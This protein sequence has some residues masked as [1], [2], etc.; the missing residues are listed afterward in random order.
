MLLLSTSLAIGQAATGEVNGTVT[1][2]SGAFVPDATVT[3]TNQGTNISDKASTNAS[4]HFLF[5]N[6][7]PGKYALAV[8]KQGFKKVEVPAFELGVNQAITQP[9]SLGVGSASETVEV[10]AQSPLLQASSSELGTVIPEKA[11]NDLPL[12]GRNFTQLLTLTPGATPVSTAQ[13]S[14]VGVLDAGI[15]GIPGSDFSKPSLHGQQN[16]STLYFLDGIINTDLRGPVYGVLPII[17]AMQEFKVQSHNDKAEYGGVTGGIV[18]VV[19]KSG[20][21]YF[22]GSAWEFLRNNFFDARD[23]FKDARS[24]GPAAFHQNEFGG[25]VGGP[26]I[27]DKT[28]FYAGYEGW[29][30]S[31]PTQNFA[32]VPTQLELSGDFTQSASPN[33]IYNPYSTRAGTKP[34]SYVRDPFRCDSSGNPLPTNSSG[35]Q[36]QTTGT[37]CNKLPASLISP[38]MQGFLK[39]YLAPPNFSGTAG[40]NYVETRPT[41][42]NDNTWTA[43]IDHR[44]RDADNVFFR[45]TQMYVHHLD[46]VV[47][48]YESQPSNYH[49]NDFGGGWVHAFSP[50]LILDVSAGAL[51]KPYVFNQAQ[52]S[53]GTSTMKQLGLNVDQFDG[54][55]ATL[56]S[57]WLTNEI[58]NRGD[59]IRRNPDWSATGNLNWLKGNHNFRMGGQYIYVARQQINTFQSFGFSGSMTSCPQGSSPCYPNPGGGAGGLSLA[60]ALLGLPTS[61]SGELPSSGEVHFKLATWSLYGED[62]WKALPTLT[63]NLGLRWDFLTQ[64]QV[65]GPRLFNSLDLFNQNWLIGA[66]SIPACNQAPQNPCFPGAG[67][68]TV[69]FSNHILL[70]GKKSFNDPA[71]ND[72]YGPRFGLAWQLH[73][74]TVI[75]GG[76]GMFWDALPARSQYVQNDIEA[77]QWPWVR[78]FSG[79]PNTAGA[80]LQP[81]ASVVGQGSLTPP[82]SP[83]NSLQSSYFDAPN[84]KDGWSEQWNLEIEQQIHSNSMFAIAYVG[85]RNGRMAYTGNANAAPHPSSSNSAAVDATRAIPWMTPGLH[86]TMPLAYGN[87]NA[88]ETK[89][90]RHFTK[91]LM[92]LVSYTWSKSLDDSSGYF[93]VENGAGQGGSSVQNFFDPRSNY[94]VSGY[95]VPH[96]FSWYTVWELPAGKGKRWLQSGPASWLLGNWQ[97][98]YIFQARSGQPF[99]LNVSGDPANISGSG[100]VG[101]VSGY[102]R[103]NLIDNPIPAKQTAA[104]WFNPSAFSIPVGSFGNFGRNQLRSSHVVNMDFSMFK[105]VPM[106]ETREL[107]FQFQAFNI[108]NIQNLAAPGSSGSSN[109]TTIGNKGAG[110]VSSIVGSP[111]E[112]QFGVRFV[113]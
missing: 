99:N 96:F 95:D 103:P 15:S 33:Q 39:A 66:S 9:V 55:V 111:R 93:G 59:S 32:L 74:N 5:I 27:K 88:L 77:A 43:R 81:I 82:A 107:Q 90:Q 105:N 49:A 26:I 58:G 68:A 76:I 21:D 48:T 85:S 97:A 4:G 2:Q 79:S 14:G 92:T 7:Q 64:P 67:L 108:F 44:F 25:A 51:L 40:Q 84:F 102:S 50:N 6:L 110:I 101:T 19:S 100:A 38:A 3:I 71:I 65:I 22:H 70:T 62:E 29:R 63:V 42:D 37:P 89:F 12:N 60:T 11:V 36:S 45:F 52:S 91:G 109:G 47:G 10:S 113:F 86:Y 94:S 83:W 87:Y 104:Q 75:R 106:G 1:D 35:L 30:Y 28:F 53:V 24:T 34:G 73:P 57:P 41:I 23:P 72:N 112:M 13:G 18:N 61:S 16:R 8:E 98:N 20:T 46:R 78:G 31:K 69:P 80:P 54:M 56:S 17:D